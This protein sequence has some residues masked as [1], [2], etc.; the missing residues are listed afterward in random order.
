MF[1]FR[2]CSYVCKLL[3]QHIFCNQFKNI[4]ICFA[5]GMNQTQ[6]H[7]SKKSFAINIF[8]YR[9]HCPKKPKHDI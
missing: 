6:Q 3:D 9:V 4:E 7:G 8:R 1:F 5:F 2:T